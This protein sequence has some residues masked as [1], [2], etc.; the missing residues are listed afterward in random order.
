MSSATSAKRGHT[1]CAPQIRRAPVFVDDVVGRLRSVGSCV[2][3]V[4][5][6]DAADI[7]EDALASAG[8]SGMPEQQDRGDAARR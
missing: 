5:P 6:P 1:G 8:R 4:I 2:L 3:R 7:V